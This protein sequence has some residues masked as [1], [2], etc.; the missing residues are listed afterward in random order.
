ML[1]KGKIN[2]LS[3]RNKQKNF[4]KLKKNEYDVNRFPVGKRDGEGQEK[5][6]RKIVLIMGDKEKR[7]ER[8][9]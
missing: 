1:L 2:A 9:C 5:R 4:N 3:K 8:E 6:K 7:I